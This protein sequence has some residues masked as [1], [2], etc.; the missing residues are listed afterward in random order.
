MMT[1]LLFFCLFRCRSLTGRVGSA[2]Y[3]IAI[4]NYMSIPHF[5]EFSWCILQEIE[6]FKF[7]IV[8]LRLMMRPRISERI[9]SMMYAV[10]LRAAA[11]AD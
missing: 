9:N 6:N 10:A 7:F 8:C 5:V 2:Q 11:G 1:S 4:D 3:K